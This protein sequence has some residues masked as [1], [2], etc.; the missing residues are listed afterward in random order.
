MKS[1]IFQ[2]LISKLKLDWKRY[3]LDHLFSNVAKC[4]LPLSF[5]FFKYNGSRKVG[6][7]YHLV[8]DTY[9]RP[10]YKTTIKLFLKTTLNINVNPHIL[11]IYIYFEELNNTLIRLEVSPID[12]RVSTFL[13]A[14][15]CF[16]FKIILIF[17]FNS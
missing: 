8:L 1:V 16:S 3:F 15:S 6:T 7:K 17:V 4:S 14:E 12:F 10:C 11:S 2:N 9:F 5:L 13:K